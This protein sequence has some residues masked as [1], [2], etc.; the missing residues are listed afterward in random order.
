MMLHSSEMGIVLG[1][2]I[3]DSEILC[4]LMLGRNITQL[5]KTDLAWIENLRL[6]NIYIQYLLI[7]YYIVCFGIQNS[8]YNY[9]F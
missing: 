6:L 4:A 7:N 8:L 1:R 9:F 5:S 2:N 3:L